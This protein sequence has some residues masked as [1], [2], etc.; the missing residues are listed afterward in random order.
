M[1]QIG[2]RGKQSRRSKKRKTIT[3]SKRKQSRSDFS[4]IKN[5]A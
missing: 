4:K 5:V 3:I 1:K 2:G